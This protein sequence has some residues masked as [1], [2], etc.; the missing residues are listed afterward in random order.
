M[1]MLATIGMMAV[2]IASSMMVM[3]NPV[4]GFIAFALV[5]VVHNRTANDCTC[6]DRTFADLVTGIRVTDIDGCCNR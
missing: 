6:D 2:V 1:E 3:A 4:A 5:M